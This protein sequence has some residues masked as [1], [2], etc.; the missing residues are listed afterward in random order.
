[1]TYPL[2]RKSNSFTNCSNRLQRHG[3]GAVYLNIFHKDVIDF[4]ATK[5]ENADEKVRMKTLS[6]GLVV[7]DKFYELVAKGEYMYL[8]SPYDIKNEYGVP[9]SQF[10]ITKHYQELVD[11]PRIHKDKVLARDLENEISKLQQE[12]GYPYIMNVDTVNDNHYVNGKVSI[13]NLC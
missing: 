13:S 3:A 12:S 8:F 7:P 10:D 11:N 1:M 4:L 6:L 5:K 9:M 2:L